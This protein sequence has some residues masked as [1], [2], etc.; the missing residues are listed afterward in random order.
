MTRPGNPNT[1][2]VR[3]GRITKA[4]LE[5]VFRSWEREESESILVLE[6]VAAFLGPARVKLTK[7][8][9][10]QNKLLVRAH[11]IDLR[12]LFSDPNWDAALKADEAK[13]GGW[14]EWPG[15]AC[16]V[17]PDTMVEVRFR[18]GTGS[19]PIQALTAH[20]IRWPNAAGTYSASPTDVV[21]YRV[22]KSHH[23]KDT[24][25][26]WSGGENPCVPYN[27]Q[28]EIELRGRSFVSTTADK[29]YWAHG[30]NYADD[31]I[32]FRVMS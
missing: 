17:P 8:A 31:V 6:A 22:V 15:G 2:A 5:K 27:R 29:V 1:N 21:A 23:L 26:S 10:E 16:P 18:S 13:N 20:W 30:S 19:K 3:D 14:I 25:Y 11:D 12:H 28:V 7:E 4:Q 24:W 9:A 32:A